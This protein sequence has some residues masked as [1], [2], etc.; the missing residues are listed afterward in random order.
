VLN[1]ELARLTNWMERIAQADQAID[2]GFIS[3]HAG[4]STT[5]GF[6]ANDQSFGPERRD[7]FVPG[8]LQHV[9]SI[10]R[11]SLP[12]LSVPG[13]VGELEANNPEAAA[14]QPGGEEVHESRIHRCTRTMSHR[15]CLCGVARSIN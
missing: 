13:H 2:A 6:S 15:N 9:L 1:T 12:C 3:D 14:G 4:D 11:L 7:N 10:R 5:H 8:G